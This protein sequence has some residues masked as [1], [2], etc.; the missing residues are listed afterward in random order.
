MIGPTAGRPVGRTCPVAAP[1]VMVARLE[2]SP[3]ALVSLALALLLSRV[4]GR[5]AIARG[6]SVGV[7]R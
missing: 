3:F 2:P 4:G 5:A 6:A 7:M 1:V